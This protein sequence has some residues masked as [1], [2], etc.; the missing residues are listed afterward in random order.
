M[1]LQPLEL[2]KKLTDARKKALSFSQYPAQIPVD[3]GFSYLVQDAAI[4]IWPDEIV[5]WKIGRLS[6]EAQ[7]IHKTERL[8]GPIF[9]KRL[10]KA[11]NETNLVSIIEG[12]F[13]AV[14]AEFVFEIGQDADANKVE[15][16]ETEAFELLASVHAGVELAGSPIFDIN[17]YGPLVV[18]SDFGNNFGLILAQKL[19]DFSDESQ[20]SSENCLKFTTQTRING[21]IV[22][23]G[24]LFSIPNGPLAAIAW[25]AGHLAKRNRP[26]KR[27]QLISSGAT[28]GIHD[29]TI[30]D[31]ANVCFSSNNNNI[32][33]VAIK[34]NYLTENWLEK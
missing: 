25:L 1:N 20:L 33:D 13:A 12:G 21:E 29:F 15:Y 5:G 9:K 4:D 2:A 24:G 3:L 11:S 18:A 34:A 27:G 7:D 26:L 23:S 14:E 19:L 28:T 10:W 16:S 6:P 8:S 22:G 30:Q 31:S 17:S 32:S